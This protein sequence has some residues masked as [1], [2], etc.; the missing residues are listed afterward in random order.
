MGADPFIGEVQMFGGNFAPRGWALCDG[1]LLAVASNDALF[2]LLGTRYGGD[3]RT[4]FGLPDLRSRI[5][6][7][8]GQGPGL[9]NRVLGAKLGTESETLTANQ[10]P[11]HTH[12]WQ[13]TAGAASAT[14]PQGARLA[15]ATVYSPDAPDTTLSASA[16]TRS[17]GGGLSHTNEQ[18]FLVVNYIIA[19]W[20]IYPSRN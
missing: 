2:S 6:I 5:P 9:T 11:A 16:V 18:P 15:A 4:S 3:G 20:G 13:T 7:G 8:A 14:N 17:S 12:D 10:V 19:L 1:Q